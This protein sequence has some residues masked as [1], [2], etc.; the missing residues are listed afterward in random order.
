MIDHNLIDKIFDI[1]TDDDF[2]SVALEVFRFQYRNNALYRRFVDLLSVDVSKVKRW[3]DVPCLPI[4]CF[5]TNKVVAFDTEP[6]DYFQSSA[7]TSM[8]TSKH[9]FFTGEVYTR[10]F[11]NTF[12]LFWGDPSQYCIL[13]LLPNYLHQTHSSLIFMVRELIKQTGCEY[14]GFYDT[15]TP[16]LVEYLKNPECLPKRLILFGVSYSL[17]DLVESYDFSLG[18][19]IVFETGGMKGRRKEMVREEL[20]SLLTNGLGVKSIASEY[21]MTELF[22]QAYSKGNGIYNCPPWMKIAIRDVNSPL[23]RLPRGRAGGIDVI[24]LAN[25]Y[26][27]SFISTQD[28]GRMHNDGSFEVQGRFDYSDTRGCNLL[29]AM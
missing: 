22:S 21:G 1:Q 24:D 12:S 26:S 28:I 6:I 25:I 18:D 9:Y 14:S 23:V 8:V 16:Q 4:E 7:T 13:A 10:S 20:H 3:E 2:N 17:L 11:L 15:I 27:C 29:T 19:A 5:K